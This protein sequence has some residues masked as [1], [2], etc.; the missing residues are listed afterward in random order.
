MTPK[1][2]LLSNVEIAKIHE[3]KLTAALDYLK[4]VLPVNDILFE[5]LLL[6]KNINL[7]YSCSL[8]LLNFWKNLLKEIYKL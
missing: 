5:P 8:K 6:I 7:M 4:N 2:L 1:E 3:E